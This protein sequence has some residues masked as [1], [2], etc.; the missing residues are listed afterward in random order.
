MKEGPDMENSK[1]D[2]QIQDAVR[3]GLEHEP[4]VD[5]NRIGIT[6]DHGLVFL[7]GHVL[8]LTQ[9]QEIE[10]IALRVDG[11]RAVVDEMKSRP[12]RWGLNEVDL[13]CA[14]T[15]ALQRPGVLADGRVKVIVQGGKV[16]LEG[17]VGSPDEKDV[18]ATAVR[19]AIGR[20]GTVDD[21]ITIEPAAV[22]WPSSEGWRA[23]APVPS[24]GPSPETC[25]MVIAGESFTDEGI[26]VSHAR[27]REF[28]EIRGEGETPRQGVNRLA[29]RLERAR[30]HAREPWQRAA[31]ER[32][33]D[34]VK[35]YRSTL[36]TETA[37]AVAA[38][39]FDD[40]G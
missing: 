30:E 26:R 38:G 21:E 27:H 37:G 1:S 3:E 2:K 6:A 28:P 31:I 13:A 12:G 5:A 19:A 4:L 34:D 16:R 15:D 20:D 23:G 35:A 24:G 8:G 40:L 33:I 39:G 10:E 7:S 25:T 36:T 9:R 32:A 17:V 18:I 29:D 14:A 11:V 22:P